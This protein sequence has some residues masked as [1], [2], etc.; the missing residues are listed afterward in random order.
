MHLNCPH[1][2]NPIEVVDEEEAKEVV[3][4]SCG[5]SIQLDPGRT[6]TWLPTQRP[7]SLLKFEFLE[8]LGVGGHG[9]VYKARD[10]ELDRTVAIKIPRAGNLATPEDV[11]RFLREARA[12]AQLKHPSIVS[13]HDAGSSDGTCY[14]VSEYVPGATLADRLATGRL[15]FREAAELMAQ[16][17]DALDYAHRQGV[18][19]RDLKP[20]NIMLHALRRGHRTVTERPMTPA[21]GTDSHTPS[22]FSPS[23]PVTLGRSCQPRVIHGPRQCSDSTR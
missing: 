14:L 21:L 2:H 20:S 9:T 6:K 23:H 8:E 1:C 7:R 18:I 17:A 3:C 13:V 11:D 15:S 22:A 5:S 16:V 10:T 4:P 12:A 19:H